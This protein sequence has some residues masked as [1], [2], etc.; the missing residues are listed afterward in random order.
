MK[1]S[2]RTV[3]ATPKIFISSVKNYVSQRTPVVQLS[4]TSNSGEQKNHRAKVTTTKCYFGGSRPWFCCESCNRRAGVLYLNENGYQ[5]V[6][7]ECAGLSY[8]SQKLGGSSRLLMRCFD[9]DERAGAV[10]DGLQRA[11]FLHKGMPTHRLRLFLTYR[12]KAER[13]SRVFTN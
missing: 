5:L 2:R 11:K 8:R 12:Q 4:I 9:A 6:C 3:E 10:F 7:R 1:L 13:L